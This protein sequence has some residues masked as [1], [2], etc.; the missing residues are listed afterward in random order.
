[1]R[2][3]RQLISAG[4]GALSSVLG[5]GVIGGIA[6]GMYVLRAGRQQWQRDR[7]DARTERSHR[8]AMSIAEAVAR[9]EEAVV[10]WQVARHDTIGL[11]STYNEAA[12]SV[13]VQSMALT[14]G[15][16][17]SRVQNHVQLAGRLIAVA[18]KSVGSPFPQACWSPCGSTLTP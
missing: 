9:L 16:M 8:A 10:A 15:D 12:R 17:R 1:M 11:T 3:Q 2:S 4:Y 14:D 13:A 18:Q 6:S 5:A 7:D